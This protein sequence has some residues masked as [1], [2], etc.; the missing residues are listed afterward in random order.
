MCSLVLFNWTMTRSPRCS[1]L[2]SCISISSPCCFAKLPSPD[3]PT[4]DT[5]H[6]RCIDK[7]HCTTLHTPHY[8]TSAMVLGSAALI[9][10]AE[11]LLNY[12]YL[13]DMS[14]KFVHKLASLHAPC[15]SPYCTPVTAAA[16]CSPASA[17]ETVADS[18]SMHMA[19]WQVG[20]EEECSTT[21]ASCNFW[22]CLMSARVGKEN[23]FLSK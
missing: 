12:N 17:T 9:N 20:L 3:K 14:I 18:C 22:L 4:R 5:H 11:A 23:S 1:F 7:K 10:R 13:S 15:C 2:L 8:C 19:Q 16:V 21:T 6:S